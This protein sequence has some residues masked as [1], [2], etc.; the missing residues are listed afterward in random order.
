LALLIAVV[1]AL[2]GVTLPRLARTPAAAAHIALM[3]ERGIDPSAKFY[4]ELDA[5][6]RVLAEIDRAKELDRGAWW[7]PSCWRRSG[8]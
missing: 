3:K 1:A 5:L 8:E 4:T 6:P 7:K 2:W